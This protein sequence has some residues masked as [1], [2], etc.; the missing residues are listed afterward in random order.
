MKNKFIDF[1]VYFFRF[2][3]FIITF[4]IVFAFLTFSATTVRI[5]PPA[6]SS[7]ISFKAILPCPEL[8]QT[9]QPL[10]E[11]EGCLLIDQGILIETLDGGSQLAAL[12]EEQL[13]NPASVLKIAT[14]LAALEKWGANYRFETSFLTDGYIDPDNHTLYG[15]LVF[16]SEGDPTFRLKMA[17]ELIRQLRK[18]GIRRVQGDFVVDGPFSIN[19]NYDEIESIR[20][21][22]KYLRRLGLS[23]S[24]ETLWQKRTATPQV[25]HYSRSLLEILQYQNA[26]SSNPIAERLGALLGGPDALTL[27]LIQYCGL[28]LDDIFITHTSGLDH[29][30]ISAK[31]ML[32]IL[33]KLY[34]WCQ[35]NQVPV[36]SVL[37]IAG[38]DASTLRGRF[39]Q[40]EYNGG[41]MAKTGTLLETDAGVSALAGFIHTRKYG[42]L[43]F[44]LFNSRGDVL[45]YQRWQNKF[46]KSI[47]DRAGGVIPFRTTP[48]L[49]FSVYAGHQILNHQQVDFS[50]SHL[51]SD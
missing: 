9:M 24:G 8:E 44:T 32:K 45:V 1:G 19:S 37:P 36:D 23:I 40:A 49:E 35:D 41:I 18:S 39:R 31:G 47:I 33:R 11:K 30:R 51:F 14:T 48:R 2:E 22:R 26:Y 46:L 15:D 28:K 5:P 12:N 17:H 27:Y 20:R 29:N 21:L 34:G 3:F 43:V 42:I 13:F 4:I 16:F 10:L 6:E 50:T 25:S 7:R 38:I